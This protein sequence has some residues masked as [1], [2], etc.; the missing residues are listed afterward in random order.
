[1]SHSRKRLCIEIDGA[2][3][4]NPGPAA[5]GVV[6]KDESGVTLAEIS[7]R[8]GKATNNQAEYQALLCALAEAAKL[9][10]DQV[11]IRSD[12]ELLVKQIGGKYRVKSNHLKPLYERAKLMLQKLESFSLEQISREQNAAADALANRALDAPR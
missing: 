6:I 5:I 7:R 3:R 12:A 8:I 2:A 10:A 1:M 9:G 11:D 4:G